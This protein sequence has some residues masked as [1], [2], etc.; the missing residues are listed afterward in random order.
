MKLV[1]GHLTLK[2]GRYYAVLNYR[3]AGGQRKTKWIALGLPEKGNKRKAEAEL[4]K[5]RAEFEPPKEVGD[6]SSDMLFA[7]YLLEWLEIAKGRLAVATYSSYA[8][9]IK[10]PVGPYFRQRNLTL[11]ELEARHLQMFYSEMLRKVKPNTVIHYHAI[12][13]SALKYA[14][15]TDMLIQNVADKVDRPRKNS[16]QPVFLSAEEMQKM[17]EA[18]RGT[19]LELPVLVAAFYGFR[20]GEVLGL[21]WDA[22]DFERGTISVIRTV[23][24]ITLDGK[25]AEIEQQSAKTKSSLRTLPLIGSFRE[26]FMQVKEA[27]ELNKQVCGNCYNYEYDGFVFV[28]ELGERMRVEYL[29]NAFPKF[30]ESHGLRRMRFH[31][32]RHPYVKHTTKIFSLRLMDFQAQAYPDARRKTRG[33]CQLR[34]GGQSQSP[35]H[36][37]CN[38]KRFSYLPPQSKISRILYAISMRLSGYTSTRSISSSASSVV[39]ASASKIALDASFRLSCRACSSCFC[40]ACANTAA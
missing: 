35:V 38:R 40:F 6:L 4:A 9:M 31:D 37:L 17:F 36:P 16:F 20:R 39:S 25:Q 22:I 3:N 8:A 18:L 10:M 27:Q 21:K 19:K 24:T 32:L 23:T 12:I 28:D 7:D 29:T 1:A 34:R 5:L 30:L 26:Y 2:N 13:H 11:R 14:V 33:A 15:K